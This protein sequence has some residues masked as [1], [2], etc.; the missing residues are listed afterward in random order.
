MKI[1]FKLH[2]ERTAIKDPG[3]IF[4]FRNV[5]N[6]L[7]FVAVNFVLITFLFS[8]SSALHTY[9]LVTTPLLVLHSVSPVSVKHKANQRKWCLT[10]PNDICT[11]VNVS[12]TIKIT[13]LYDF[14]L[15]V[16]INYTIRT[17]RAN[18][19][20]TNLRKYPDLVTFIRIQYSFVFLTGVIK[21]QR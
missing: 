16:A 3:M 2:T 9:R 19:K 18:I 20:E 12:N 6:F 1:Y 21:K 17:S 14:S 10:S 7:S 11:L 8:S 15:R 5:L 4:T 13:Q